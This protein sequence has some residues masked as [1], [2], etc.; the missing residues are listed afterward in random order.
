MI[1]FVVEGVEIV[2]IVVEGVELF[3]VVLFGVGLFGVVCRYL[4]E[5]KCLNLCINIEI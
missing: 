3:G 1:I 2:V 5:I 4:L